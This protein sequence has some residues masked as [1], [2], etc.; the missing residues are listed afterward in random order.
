MEKFPIV[1]GIIEKKIFLTLLLA[2]VFISYDILKSF[3]P[4]GNNI[5]LI[6]QIGGSFAQM[7]SIL[8]PYIFKY[9]GKFSSSKKK[10]TKSNL[11]HYSILCLLSTL[12][13]GLIILYRN[14]NI[15]IEISISE[16]CTIICFKMI[17]YIIL[18]IIILKSKYYIHNTISL[19]LFC[20]F[21][22]II[23][24]IFGYLSNLNYTSFL[25]LFP[26]FI[27]D[28]FC[29]YMKYLMDKKYH[30]YWNI[31]FFMGL[32]NFILHIIEFI[33]EII[34]DPIDN[35][36]FKGIRIAETKYIILNFFLD[37][38]LNYYFRLLL[39]V[40]ILEYLSLNHMLISNIIYFAVMKFIQCVSDYDKYKNYLSFLIPAFFQI[41]S[42]LFYIELLE[43]NFCNLN[44]NT[45]RNIIKREKEDQILNE[46]S[47]D[48]EI[49][50][51]DDI[52]IK[53]TDLELDK[54]IVNDDSNEN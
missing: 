18:S 51:E 33:V 23:D 48:D 54:L 6:N 2:L 9:K 37:V 44:K 11:K 53:E 46:S 40:L 17:F 24:Y 3:I 12:L 38:I 25:I 28:L 5:L 47:F 43:F 42:L 8:F 32:M 22:I 1:L 14:L 7:L 16:L 21:T 31:L 13:F 27:D 41:L 20:I 30:S 35:P 50:I 34:K 10:C 4:E 49:E 45:K 39:S 19:I 26:E 15:T 29:C 52:F 36:V